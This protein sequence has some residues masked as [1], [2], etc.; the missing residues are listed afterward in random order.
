MEEYK[1]KRIDETYTFKCH[2]MLV[3]NTVS[4]R[5]FRLD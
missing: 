5:I 1:R 4:R 2:V 3:Y